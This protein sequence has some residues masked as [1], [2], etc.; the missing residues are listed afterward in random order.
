MIH[1][2][3]K[4][5]TDGVH[6]LSNITMMDGVPKLGNIVMMDGV[7]ELKNLASACVLLFLP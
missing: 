5:M 1:F 3:H 2:G 7:P 4:A 6:K